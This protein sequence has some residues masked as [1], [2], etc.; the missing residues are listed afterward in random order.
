MA[1]H[2]LEHYIANVIDALRYGFTGAGYGDGPFGRIRQHLG[3]DLD[4]GS[5]HFSDLLDLGTAF[6]DER[7]A[8]AGRDD[9]T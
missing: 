5:R 7:T 1:N 4:R 3:G 8:L 2:Y 6:A 9:Q